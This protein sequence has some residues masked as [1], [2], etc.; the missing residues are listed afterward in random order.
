MYKNAE[1]HKKRKIF[2]KNSN[3]TLQKKNV[4]CII[5]NSKIAGI[6]KWA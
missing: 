2:I 6:V 5:Y 1:K 4:C 3:K